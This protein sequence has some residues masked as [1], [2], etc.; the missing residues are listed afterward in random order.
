MLVI[1]KMTFRQLLCQPLL[2]W[3]CFGIVLISEVA[4]SFAEVVSFG[5]VEQAVLNCAQATAWLGILVSVLLSSHMVLGKEID[6]K[7][8]LTIFSKPISHFSFLAGKFLALFSYITILFL[9]QGIMVLKVGFVY[10]WS[11]D[12]YIYFAAA[13]FYVFF[14][15]LMLLG[16]SIFSCCL[17]GSYASLFLILFLWI[18]PVYLTKFLWLPLGIFL[19]MWDQF[20]LSYFIFH[21]LPLPY[22]EFLPFGLYAIGYM[23]VMVLL[24]S[25]I[26]ERRQY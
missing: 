3:L 26:L 7:V 13:M 18:I 8:A 16:L 20:D 23:V 25:M 24:G 6:E 19:P 22:D 11:L 9:V 14:Q 21:Q 5:N 10:E 4:P 1:F 17:C 15:G 2:W 12:G